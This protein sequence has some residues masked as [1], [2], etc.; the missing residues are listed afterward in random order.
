MTNHDAA[1][2]SDIDIE[3]RAEDAGERFEVVGRAGWVAKGFV[4]L[5]V[6]VLFVRIALGSSSGEEANQAGAVEKIAEQPA[7][8]VLLVAL[9]VG[10]AL[11]AIWRLLTAVLPG[12]WTGRALLDRI[13]YLVSAGIY[14]SLLLTIVGVIRQSSSSSGEREDRMVEGAVK[15]VLSM[16][17]GRVLVVVGGLVVIG[18][19]AAFIKKGVTRSFRDQMSG[20]HGIEG[21]MIDRLGTVGWI[22]RGASM[23]IIG[24]FLIRAAWL[25]DPDEAAGLDDSIRQLADHPVG[26]ALSVAVGLGFIAYGVFAGLSARHRDLEGPRND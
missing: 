13:G 11:Y 16:T 3:E 8:R 10:L 18:I 7:G 25:F 26:A 14:S 23:G 12:D 19:G 4:Y 17:A 6:G 22:A 21:T 5:L 2:L 9:G 15:D 20:D 1:I 24:G